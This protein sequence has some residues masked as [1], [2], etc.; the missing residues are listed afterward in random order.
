M[1]LFVYG[2]LL[3]HDLMATV[4][5]PGAFAPLRASLPDYRVRPI[6]GEVFPCIAP[7]PGQAADGIV[8]C[9]LSPAQI[10]R[11][12]LYEGEFGYRLEEV[13]VVVDGASRKASCYMPPDGIEEGQG[14]WSLD[15]WEATHLSPGLLAATELFSHRPLPETGALRRMWPMMEARAWSKHR[16]VA[17]PATIRHD[18][19]PGDAR[20]VAAHPPQGSFFRFQ[21][22]DVTHRRF[23][24]TRS[25]VMVRETFLGCDAALVLPYDPARDRVLLVEQVRM[26][27]LA[28][29]DP[30]PWMLEPVAG[31]I[32]ARETPQDA[33]LREAKEEANLDIRR[34]EPA[35]DFYASPGESSSYFYCFVGLCDLPDDKRY[36]GGLADEH[37]DLRLH[38]LDFADAMGLAAS[39]EVA[40]GP[41]QMLLY[42]LAYHR[43]RLRALS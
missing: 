41:L 23:D 42:W 15:A 4:A 27:P 24:G 37:E 5:G 9:D 35:A 3:S 31:M 33:A 22:V 34:L 2:T 6:A 38:P 26:G 30:N 12:D 17:A 20:I 14:E 36:H 1:D 21:G 25:H 18:P 39:G 16:A 29:H 43:D 7:A 10:A 11:L 32:D 19:K 13:S 28:R 8:W 40:T